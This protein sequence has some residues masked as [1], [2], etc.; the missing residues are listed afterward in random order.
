MKLMEVNLFGLIKFG[1]KVHMEEFQ[2]K[3]ILYMNHLSEFLKIEDNALR[4]DKHESLS[5][6]SSITNMEISHKGRK[7]GYAEN[8]RLSL[9]HNELGGNIYSMYALFTVDKP[10][11]IQIDNRCKEFGNACV[12]V[13]KIDEFI[14]RI[15]N[16]AAKQEIELIFGPV[17]YLSTKEYIGNWSVFKKPLEYYYQK[18]FRFFVRRDNSGPFCLNIGSIKD[19]SIIMDAG[20]LEK[21]RIEKK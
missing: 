1:Q 16:E 10:E 15:K 11:E 4:G 7:L 13:T 18:E 12:I 9:W 21:L 6:I 5:E 17:D 3:G 19:I 8:G 20:D 2:E 14:S